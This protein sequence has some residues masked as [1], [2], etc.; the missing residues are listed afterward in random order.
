MQYILLF[1]CTDSDKVPN[2]EVPKE[3]I[4]TNAEW[5]NCEVSYYRTNIIIVCPRRGTKNIYSFCFSF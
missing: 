5:P 1:T 4:N 3:G 2:N